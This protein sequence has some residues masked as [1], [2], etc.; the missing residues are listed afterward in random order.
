MR[1]GA[2]LAMLV[3]AACSSD[4]VGVPESSRSGE[5]VAV[6]KGSALVITNE[7]TSAVR[8]GAVESVM[9]EQALIL[10]CFGSR[11]CGD[12]L[13]AGKSI[14]IALADVPGY[15]ATADAVTVLYWTPDTAGP[16]DGAAVARLEVG[17]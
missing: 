14:T 3:V 6:V 8:V 2:V 4:P 7:G 17:L 1:A 15:S 10:W 9:L 12:A 16:D 5:L 13:P 11:D